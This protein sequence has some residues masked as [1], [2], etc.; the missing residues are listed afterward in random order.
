MTKGEIR[1]AR[2]MARAEG[3]P[4]EGELALDRGTQPHEFSES[5]RGRRTL[6]KWARRYDA[7][8][9]APESDYDR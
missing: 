4:F 8:D 7:L 2:R 6:D 3:R 1:R 9:G 5:P